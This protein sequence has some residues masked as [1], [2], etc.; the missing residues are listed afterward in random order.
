ASATDTTA[1]TVSITSPAGSGF[2]TNANSVTVAG[3]AV[4]NVGVTQVT[5]VTDRGA[6]GTASGT[7]AWT[8]AGIAL[9]PGANV[10]TVTAR[11]AAGNAG[12]ATVS[13]AYDPTAPT[14][15]ITGPAAGATVSGAVGGGVRWRAGASGTGGVGGVQ[16][17]VDGGARG[18]EA[19]GAPWT[20]TWDATG[21]A[22]GAHTLTARARDAAGNTAVSAGVAVT[23]AN[24]GPTGLV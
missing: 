1:P 4:D 2:T 3:T 12:T 22:N 15:A 6:S 7:T 17:L 9:Q 19:L 16:L 8:A 21:A 18:A 23:V 5:W 14:V 24:A 13:V 20:V 10:V 11:D